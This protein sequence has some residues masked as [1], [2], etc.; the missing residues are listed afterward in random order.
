MSSKSQKFYTLE[1]K[2]GQYNVM[3][4]CYKYSKTKV[5]QYFKTATK[6]LV[7]ENKCKQQ[8]LHNIQVGW[9]CCER[10]VCGVHPAQK[11]FS[12]ITSAECGTWAENKNNLNCFTVKYQNRHTY[13]L[14]TLYCLKTLLMV[15][16]KLKFP[17]IKITYRWSSPALLV[18]SSVVRCALTH[19]SHGAV[20]GHD[21]VT[22]SENWPLIWEGTWH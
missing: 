7:P 3:A 5:L 18:G 10:R 16:G 11:I 17:H 8:H 9:D 1:K 15:H 22:F 12:S 21:T 19:H 4:M 6:T 13:D 2:A 14:K 20:F